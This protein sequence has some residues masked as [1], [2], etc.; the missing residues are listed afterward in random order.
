MKLIKML[1]LSSRCENL[2]YMPKLEKQIFLYM[3]ITLCYIFLPKQYLL[4]VITVMLYKIYF[5]S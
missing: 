5:E 4:L 3:I 2:L 1:L